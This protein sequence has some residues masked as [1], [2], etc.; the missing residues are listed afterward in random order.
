MAAIRDQFPSGLRILVVDD[1]A[2]C[3]IILQKMLLRLMYQ[4][5]ICSQADVALTMLR[6]KKD[7][8]D[9]VL[10]DVHM[11][12]MNGYKL[13]QLVGLEMDLPV[14]MMSV[15]GRTATVMAGIKHG[16]CDYLIKPIRP[17]ELKNIWQHVVRRRCT[18]N[19]EIIRRKLEDSNKNTSSSSF[20]TIL[21]MSE[22]SEGSLKQRRKKKKKK[23]KRSVDREDNE[24]ED[25]DDLLDPGT[26]SKKSRIV[27][28]I[29]LHQQ[30]ANAVN[31]LGLEKAV[32]KRILEL[33][34]VPGLSRENVASHLQKFR[35]YLK[36]I[37]DVARHSKDAKAM[38][39]YENVQALVSSGQLHPQTLAA[40]V[41]RPVHNHLSGGY[42]VWVPANDN[43]GTS[44]NENFSI[45]A[46]SALNGSVSAT[47]SMAVHGL[48]SSA[49]LIQQ[50]D[51]FNYNNTDYRVK[52]GNG[53]N[54]NEES[55][56][57]ERSSRLRNNH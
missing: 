16:A 4:V 17:E 27:W 40:L 31:Q 44:Q 3:L 21:S 53:S 12:G 35:L 41:G 43:L 14:I 28:S 22:C 47:A 23:K 38:E 11:P 10:S 6:E 32:P 46:S 57:F 26:D 15:D 42:G 33:M 30:F 13:L 8:F 45:H 36:R 9:L 34:N 29:E 51:G 56:N 20:E 55:W 25:A 54:V 19:K 5:T 48:S 37:N 39:R 52:Q 50:S 24:E 18:M 1:D 2:S 49:N 7:S